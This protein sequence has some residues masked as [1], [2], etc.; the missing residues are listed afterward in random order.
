[1][2][3]GVFELSCIYVY[4]YAPCSQVSNSVISI[5]KWDELGALID[6]EVPVPEGVGPVLDLEPFQLDNVALAAQRKSDARLQAIV[7]NQV[8]ASDCGKYSWLISHRGPDWDEE[9]WVRRLY[10]CLKC[11]ESELGV[12]VLDISRDG[13]K[14]EKV[15]K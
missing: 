11:K 6:E 12:Q 2:D 13:Q 10:Y 8:P 3:Y 5:E 7:N 9:T 15:L 14:W 4:S 1:M